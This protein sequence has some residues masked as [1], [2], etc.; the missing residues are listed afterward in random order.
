VEIE[1][2]SPKP[3]ELVLV[4]YSWLC[5][6]PEKLLGGLSNLV[7]LSS[8]FWFCYCEITAFGELGRSDKLV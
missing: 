8:P 4:H 2:T 3:L 5:S 1:I 7:E 6:N